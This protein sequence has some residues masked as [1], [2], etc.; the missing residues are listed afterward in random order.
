MT[1][2]YGS[3]FFT[4]GERKMKIS[5][6]LKTAASSVI[7]A[8]SFM[9]VPTVAQAGIPVFDVAAVTELIKNE[10]RHLDKLTHYAEQIAKYE[11]QINQLQREY[12][13][14]TGIK[15]SDILD[16]GIQGQAQRVRLKHA[17]EGTGTTFG[18]GLP[19]SPTTEMTNY[20]KEYRLLKPEELHPDSVELQ[21]E[22]RLLQQTLYA[23]DAAT[24]ET[25]QAREERLNIYK[26]LAD[27]SAAATD[28]KASLEVNN[29]LLLENG[30][31]LALLIEL[32]TAQLAASGVELRQKARGQQTVAGLFG[33][34]GDGS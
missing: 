8:A 19:D 34:A 23:V 6:T 28:M 26:E 3:P 2:R 4:K 7:L 24:G 30:R 25:A 20:Y 16:P 1:L 10:S 21:R 9:S 33:E 17:I 14:I 18:L 15:F 29:A 32:Q 31:N 27:K 12:D 5:K 13:S 22:A 11:Q